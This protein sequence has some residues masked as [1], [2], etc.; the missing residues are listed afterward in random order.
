MLRD[1]FILIGKLTQKGYQ[2]PDNQSR[3]LCDK[4]AFSSPFLGE[5]RRGPSQEAP[6]HRPV[7]IVGKNVMTFRRLSRSKSIT[8]I[9][10]PSAHHTP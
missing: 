2:S 4:A 6:L 7:P 8:Y 9:S 3:A 10:M 1:F 5:A